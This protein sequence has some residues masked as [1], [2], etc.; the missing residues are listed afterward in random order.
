MHRVRWVFSFAFASELFSCHCKYTET[1]ER[2]K[3][4]LPPLSL[5]LA[6]L[7]LRSNWRYKVHYSLRM[8]MNTPAV[9]LSVRLFLPLFLLTQ[10]SG[11]EETREREGER[12]CLNCTAID[13]EE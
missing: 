10:A 6:P 9:T 5:A 13:E 11:G 8:T 7:E 2:V 4:S 3:E 1:F 12:R